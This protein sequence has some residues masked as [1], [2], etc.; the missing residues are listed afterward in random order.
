MD[1]NKGSAKN[2]NNSNKFARFALL[3]STFVIMWY[4]KNV[5]YFCLVSLFSK[6]LSNKGLKSLES[7]FSGTIEKRN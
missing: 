7:D 4:F 2:P 5:K 3:L 1:F 6:I